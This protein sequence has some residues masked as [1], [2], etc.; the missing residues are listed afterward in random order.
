MGSDVELMLMIAGMHFLGLICAAAL[1]LPALRGG[2]EFPSQSDRD[3]D[4]GWGHGPPKP[5]T[6]P[7]VPTGGLPLPDATPAHV[8]L[9]DHRKL[10]ELL[11]PRERRPA[12]EPAPAPAR[13]PVHQ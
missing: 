13:E 9:R 2:P 10:P 8:R 11:P 3:S 5:P 12:R 4:D 1:L 7:D 6:P